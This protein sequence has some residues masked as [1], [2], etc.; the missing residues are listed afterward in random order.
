[1]LSWARNRLIGKQAQHG[2]FEHTNSIG[3]GDLH[4]VAEALTQLERACAYGKKYGI[5][6]QGTVVI[7][8]ECQQIGGT[9]VMG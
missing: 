6:R 5:A 1:M 8:A 7:A 2:S 4:L 9:Q 3:K